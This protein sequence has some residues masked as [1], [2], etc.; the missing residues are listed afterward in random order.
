[1]STNKSNSI[2]NLQPA[3]RMTI[4]SLADEQ[5]RRNRRRRRRHASPG[6]AGVRLRFI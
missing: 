1:M 4:G 3:S 2:N 5:Q 6:E